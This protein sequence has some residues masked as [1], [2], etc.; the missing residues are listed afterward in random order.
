MVRGYRGKYKHW[1]TSGN[2]SRERSCS[3]KT[4]LTILEAQRICIRARSQGENLSWYTCE[5]CSKVHITSGDK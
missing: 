4:G 5:Y 2:P 3:S 1:H